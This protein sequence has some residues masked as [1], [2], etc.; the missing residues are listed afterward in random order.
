MPVKTFISYITDALQ[1]VLLGD[2]RDV[3]EYYFNQK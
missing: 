2:Q 3:R 1:A